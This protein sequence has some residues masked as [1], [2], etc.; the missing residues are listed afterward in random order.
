MS[1]FFLNYSG[2][3]K[4]FVSLADEEMTGLLKAYANMKQEYASVLKF[5]GE[6]LT[7]IRIDDFFGTFAAFI[8]DFE[9]RRSMWLLGKG[10]VECS[11]YA[12]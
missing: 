7:S 2:N 10:R 9:V 3:E 4:E 5:F 11:H 6:D 1:F 8:S 12:S